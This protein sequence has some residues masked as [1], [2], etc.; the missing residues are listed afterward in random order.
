MGEREG[1]RAVRT[2]PRLLR[3]RQQSKAAATGAGCGCPPA[4]SLP[5][6]G[7][8][9]GEERGWWRGGQGRASWRGGRSVRCSEE[10]V[11]VR[12]V[13]GGWLAAATPCPLPAPRRAARPRRLSPHSH[14]TPQQR[15]GAHRRRHEARGWRRDI[16]GEARPRGVAGGDAGGGGG[17]AARMRARQRG[18]THMERRGRAARAQLYRRVSSLRKTKDQQKEGAGRA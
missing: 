16:I 7:G 14:H 10:G 13:G 3:R 6:K 17:V 12:G 15:A 9:T 18:W 2:A 1:S 4:R 8:G 5:R 11:V